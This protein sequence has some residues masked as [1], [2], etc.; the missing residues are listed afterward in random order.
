MS[1]AAI[2]A[3]SAFYEIYSQDKT[4]K[5]LDSAE[6]KLRQ[7]GARIGTIGVAM[8]GFAAAGLTAIG[9]MVKSFAGAG[10]QISDAMNVTGL[11][12][13]FLQT[14]Q[15]GAADAGVA[16]DALVGSVTK[17]NKLLA[18][19]ATGGKKANATLAMLG[20]T[21]SDLMEM[22]PDER[23]KAL[24][25]AIERIPDPAQRAAAAMAVFGKSGAK[26]L[27]AL[28]GGMQALNDQMADLK[29]RGLIMSDEDRQLAVQAEGAFLS[30]SLAL[31]RVTQ[32]IAAA[33]TPA[34]LA[35]FDVI[36]TVVEGVVQF[37]DANRG[38]VA[39]ITIGLGVIGVIGVVLMG[40]G[41]AFIAA[42]LAATG[43]AAVMAGL[44]IAA[45]V[46]ASPITL[47][48]AAIVACGA[49]ALV[50]AYYLDQLFNGGAALQ[51]L[52]D[53]ATSAMNA[54]QLLW[55]AVSNGR[56]DL[57]GQMIS[58]AISTSFY[59]LI[60]TI[61]EAWNDMTIWMVQSV[62]NAMAK[63]ESQLPKFARDR[64][65][66]AGRGQSVIEG[67]KARGEVGLADDRQRAI[68]ASLAY[69]KTVAEIAALPKNKIADLLASKGVALPNMG[70]V[71]NKM[72]QSSLLSESVGTGSSI[73]AGLLGR[74]APANSAQEKQLDAQL[75]GNKLL[76]KIFGAVE[77]LEGLTAD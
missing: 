55:Q 44:G 6:A 35:V 62:V 23:F 74:A 19:A 77:G 41:A 24:A 10:D 33:A 63:L 28:E 61:K 73:A 72:M 13:D 1:I 5:G 76:D 30:L 7:F 42:S 52:K 50:S 4:S 20:L 51:F 39:G 60:L 70:N 43:F 57:A 17:S 21:A 3:G 58:Q 12:S 54:M 9:A 56:W 8:A 15:F 40:V 2:K 11:S 53:A 47:V 26:L 27:P 59:G 69:S 29:S 65:G 25:D 18:D 37:I 31:S 75:E 71:G 36:Q 16:F 38:L 48:V 45:A 32:V 64:L 68:D 34:F 67:M 66:L 22:N 49:A 14:L 46:I